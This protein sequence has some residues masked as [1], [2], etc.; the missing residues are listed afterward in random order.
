LQQ[1][2]RNLNDVIRD[3]LLPDPITFP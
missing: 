3:V 2:E 1:T